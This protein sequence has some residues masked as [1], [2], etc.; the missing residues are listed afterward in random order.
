MINRFKNISLICGI[1]LVML[2]AFPVFAQN[3][4]EINRKPLSDFGKD[5]LDPRLQNN[6]LVLSDNFLVEV[7]GELDKNGKFDLQKT[8]YIRTEG[9]E[10]IAD[11]AKSAIEAVNDSGV[12]GYLTQLGAKKINLVFAQNDEQIYAVI[13]SELDSPKRAKTLKSAF[14]YGFNDVKTKFEK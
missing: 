7:E 3:N 10:K 6:E 14:R 2:A 8:K 5:N 11:A 4:V 13:N 12:F 9:N 1:A